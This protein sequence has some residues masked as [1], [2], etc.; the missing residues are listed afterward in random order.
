MPQYL[1]TK[2]LKPDTRYRISFFVKGRDLRPLLYRD[3]GA[4]IELND[5]GG[6]HWMRHPW[7]YLFGTFDW[8]GL[9]FELKT[10]K[11]AKKM[12]EHGF[13]CLRIINATGTAWFD[14]IRVEEIP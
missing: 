8:M 7:P 6:R 5:G 12:A 4:C 11:D 2:K 14:D 3:G 9:R 1:R 13:V 10:G